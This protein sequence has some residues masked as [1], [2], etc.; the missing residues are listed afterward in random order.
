MKQLSLFLLAFLYQLTAFGQGSISPLTPYDAD[1]IETKNP[2]IGWFIMGNPAADGREWFRLV[3]VELK[4]GQSPE[5]GVTVNTPLLK[6]DHVQGSQVFYP[7]DAP[8]LV[9]GHHYGWQVYKLVNTVVVEKSEA[10]EF[11][12]A[13]PEPPVYNKYAMLRKKH[14]GTSYVAQGGKI[15]FRMDESYASETV[16]VFVYDDRMNELKKQVKDDSETGEH[17]G[18]FAVKSKGSNF[19]ELDLGNM[20]KAGV[21]Q[22]HVYDAKDQRYVLKFTVN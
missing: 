9:E 7:Y 3:V 11:I 16:R 10:W 15:F 13:L 19:Y 1:T 18:E 4:E 6:L 21:Y 5:A 12:L 17:S 2:L 14:D 22:L 8:E 20:P